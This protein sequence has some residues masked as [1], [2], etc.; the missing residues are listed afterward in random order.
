MK[1]P[2]GVTCYRLHEH[3][4]LQVLTRACLYSVLNQ[5]CDV[6][7]LVHDQC[8]ED[9]LI[10]EL[11]REFPEPQVTFIHEDERGVSRA[12]NRL[13][14]VAFPQYGYIVL[15][16]NDVELLPGSLKALV[17]FEVEHKG[18]LLYADTYGFSAFLLPRDVYRQ[19]GPFDEWY[20]FSIED[21]DYVR[22]LENSGVPFVRCPGFK[23]R[24][25]E[26]SI[27]KYVK[28]DWEELDRV[29]EAHFWQVY[30]KR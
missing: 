7:V 16:N 24:H 25:E 23:V 26:R 14:N 12:W 15:L 27:R 22:R 13:C 2:V 8:S 19:V 28:D 29:G 30:P 5:G 18:Q 17:E 20:K 6:L 9:R 11:Q 10:Q 3:P 21:W 4:R 1:V